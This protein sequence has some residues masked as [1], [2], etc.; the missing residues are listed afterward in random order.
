MLYLHVRMTKKK[1]EEKLSGRVL[2]ATMQ[3]AIL[4]N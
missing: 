2:P 4:M 3:R 1:H